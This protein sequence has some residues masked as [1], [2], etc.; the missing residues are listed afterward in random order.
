[1]WYFSSPEVVFGEGALAHLQQIEG[2]RAFV[3]SDQN[4]GE[5]GFVQAVQDHL[6]KGGLES[7]CFTEVEPDPS[8][9]TVLSGAQAMADCEPDWVVGLGGGSC[10]DAA[11]AMWVLYERPDIRPEAI[12]PVETLGLRKKARLITIP[13]TAG[14]GAE[15]T[16][17][18]VL[19]DSQEDRKLGLGSRENLADVAIVDPS[20][21]KDMP[22]RLTADTGLDALSHAVEGYASA[23]GNDF[24]DGLCL[25]AAQLIFRYLSRAYRDGSVEEA[26]ERM[27]NS[28]TLAGLGFG[29]SMS[30]LAHSMGHALGGVFHA[31]HGRAVGLCLPY[32]IEYAS[33]ENPGRYAQIARFLRLPAQAEAEGAESLVRAIRELLERL[34][35]PMSLR[36][37][38]VEREALQGRMDKLIENAENEASTVVHPRVPTPEELERLFI[39]A[40]EGQEID[41]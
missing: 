12:N 35:Q 15:A 5:L 31:P 36:A 24:G 2:R 10:M 20:L 29:N 11:K 37:A 4:L 17:M 16:W 38:G 41:F 18:I 7:D 9:E 33:R 22:P 1:M 34:E 8:L 32:T 19:T 21:S 13:T 28:A 26:R 23:W 30:G 14:T 6:A 40:H 25:K 27:A 39:Y 3:V